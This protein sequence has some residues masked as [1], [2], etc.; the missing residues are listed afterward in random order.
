M[1]TVMYGG[2]RIEIPGMS[3]TGKEEIKYDRKVVSSRHSMFGATHV[4]SVR[5]DGDDVQYEVVIGTRWH[6]FTCWAIVRRN[7]RVIYSDR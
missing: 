6:G 4:F 1:K 3:L 5:E 2:H 7:G